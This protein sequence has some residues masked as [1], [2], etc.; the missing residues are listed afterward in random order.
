MATL[1]GGQVFDAS[2]VE[3]MKA[4]EPVPTGVYDIKIVE[5][6]NKPTS[7]STEQNPAIMLVLTVEIISGEFAG[8]KLWDRLNLVNPN[9]VT[10]EIAQK[11]LSAICRATG[12]MQLTDSA[13]LHGIPMKAKVK[14]RGGG[15]GTNGKEYDASNEIAEYMPATEAVA[16]V[17]LATGT[18]WQPVLASVTPAA[19]A[20]VPS[21]GVVAGKPWEKAPPA[22]AAA[23]TPP[24]AP[25]APPKPPE[26]TYVPNAE[27]TQE[28]IDWA[29]ANPT[30]ERAIKCLNSTRVQA[31][32][33]AASAPPWARKT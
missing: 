12:V 27:F 4:L 17:S 2:T 19:P 23:P 21:G 15:K 28:W 7:T 13:Q 26:P 24:P 22:V 3:P 32:A 30:D 29:K 6:E 10:V 8:R 16:G 5:S 20:G 25:A 14:I 9:V 11:T 1:P 31:T 33:P 18:P